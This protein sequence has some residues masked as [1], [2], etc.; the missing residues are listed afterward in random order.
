MTQIPQIISFEANIGSGKSTLLRN[1]SEYF[2]HN[3]RI[4]ILQEPVDIWNTIVNTNGNT[5]LQ[6][7]YA[8]QE[9][10]AFPF[11][12]MAYISRLTLLKEAL[13]KN[14]DII[15]TE[16]CVYSDKNIFAKMLYDNKILNEIEFQVYLKWFDE[17]MKDIPEISFV[18][19]RTDPKISMERI[20]TR[21]RIGETISLEYLQECHNY[22]ENWLMNTSDIK[23]IINGNDNLITNNDLLVAVIKEIEDFMKIPCYINKKDYYTLYFDG[24]VKQ[25][26]IPNS[27]L[28]TTLN[29]CAYAYTIYY[30]YNKIFEGSEFYEKQ[31]E[32]QIK[33]LGLIHGLNKAIEVGIRKIQIECDSI[34]IINQINGIFACNSE[35]L[36]NLLFKVSQLLKK[37]DSYYLMLNDS[38]YIRMTKEKAMERL[39]MKYYI[40]DY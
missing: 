15:L 2:K 3:S 17:F 22:H 31:S 33:Y 11:Q 27:T 19:I 10:Y 21:N 26:N 34:Y 35:T 8:N 24:I 32:L 4:C 38:D 12:M 20:L 18:Y 28:M 40:N 37:F 39:N 30:N 9:K 36:K 29:N 23:L 7:Y 13:A 5:I 1:L 6:E 14:Y 25:S 16:R